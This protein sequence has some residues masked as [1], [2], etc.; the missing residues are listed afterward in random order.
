MK[1][2]FDLKF[3]EP[4]PRPT[5]AYFRGERTAIADWP[6]RSALPALVF[7]QILCLFMCNPVV[8]LGFTPAVSFL[9]L[10]L[11]IYMIAILIV[12]QNVGRLHAGLTHIFRWVLPYFLSCPHRAFLYYTPIVL[13]C[14]GS[15]ISRVFAFFL[16][17][18]RAAFLHVLAFVN[19]PLKL[20]VIVRL[21]HVADAISVIT[22]PII[23]CSG[24]LFSDWCLLVS[25]AATFSLSAGYLPWWAVRSVCLCELLVPTFGHPGYATEAPLLDLPVL[26][27]PDNRCF[28]YCF[29]CLLNYD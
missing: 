28:Y 1:D 2:F 24:L 3:E 9:I 11:I 21:V 19:T 7:I 16:C 25:L 5:A 18:A 13:V 8:M 26:T 14:V 22:A 17:W 27:P 29:V 4:C 6:V 15:S 20:L 23:L 12:V 10:A